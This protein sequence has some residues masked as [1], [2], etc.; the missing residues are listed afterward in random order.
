MAVGGGIAQSWDIA[1]PK[2]LPYACSSLAFAASVE[3][4]RR[5]WPWSPTRRRAL[6]AGAV[7]AAVA[8]GVAGNALQN[9]FNDDRYVSRGAVVDRVLA[10][11]PG[12]RVGLAGQWDGGFVPTYIL[13]G[14]RL[15]NDVDYVGAIHDGQLKEFDSPG[16]FGR[17]LSRGRYDL[18]VV[19]RS[20]FELENL[21]AIPEGPLPPLPQP[22]EVRWALDRGF[23][24]I[25]RD[26]QFVLLAS[27]EFEPGPTAS[28]IT[29]GLR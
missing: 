7:V 3:M 26:D 10:A 2:G 13:F 1:W 19:G 11:G 22:E 28:T 12:T 23:R 4:L 20:P 24:E 15:R 25:A 14:S 27:P 5:L 18:L 16:P 21:E 6:I 29:A 8:L 9:R 17:A